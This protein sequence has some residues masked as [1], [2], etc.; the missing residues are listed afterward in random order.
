MKKT[1]TLL[2]IALTCA[3]TGREKQPPRLVAD[4]AIIPDWPESPV[5][6]SRSLGLP[7]MPELKC[8]QATGQ[9][10]LPSCPGTGL[11]TSSPN[12]TPSASKR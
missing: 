10:S 12:A 4:P 3:C 8:L 11:W 2:L 6:Q 9:V 5:D 7:R 1:V